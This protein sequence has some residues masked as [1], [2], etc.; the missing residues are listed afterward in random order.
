MEIYDISSFFT[1]G[2]GTYLVVTT[3]FAELY[4]QNNNT[5]SLARNSEVSEC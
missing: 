1:D 3:C 4:I 2:Y 5:N